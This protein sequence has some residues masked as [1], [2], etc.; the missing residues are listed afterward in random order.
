MEPKRRQEAI[1]RRW[2]DVPDDDLGALGGGE[3]VQL[4]GLLGQERDGAVEKV[5]PQLRTHTVNVLPETFVQLLS[6]SLSCLHVS[7]MIMYAR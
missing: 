2:R 1:L 3:V 6:S 4:Q 7:T 5:V